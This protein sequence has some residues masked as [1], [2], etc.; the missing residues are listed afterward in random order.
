[1][2]MSL[3]LTKVLLHLL[4]I[5][6]LDQLNRFFMMT[7]RLISLLMLYLKNIGLKSEVSQQNRKH[8]FHHTKWTDQV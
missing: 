6:K 2:E 7:S 8:C 4:V 3:H 5:F 1:M